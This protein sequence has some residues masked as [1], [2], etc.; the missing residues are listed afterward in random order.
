MTS[1]TP[2][3][4]VVDDETAIRRL[5]ATL[6]DLAG[7][8]VIEAETARA[9]LEAAALQRPD[10]VIL[11]LGLPDEDGATVLKRLREWTETPVIVLSIRADE[12]EKV[13][14]LEHGAD[15]YVTKPFGSAELVARART[16]LRR[17]RTREPA[18]TVTLG[19]LTIDLAFRRVSRAGQPVTLP[20]KEYQLLALL[21]AHQG[22]V[23]T[24]GQIITELWGPAHADDIHYLRILVR[25]LRGRVEANPAVPVHVLTELGVGY[26]LA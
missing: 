5:L 17:S 16:A 20:R 12:Q 19:D 14:L 2:L 13:A 26:R 7:W 18:P 21:A 9:A 23:L 10:L 4:L 6:F 8:R 22:K 24:H 25:K 3:V 15:D 1:E 11:D